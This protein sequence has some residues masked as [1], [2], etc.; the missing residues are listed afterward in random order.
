MLWVCL[1]SALHEYWPTSASVIVF[2]VNL[3]C[4]QYANRINFLTCISLVT[5]RSY[6]HQGELLPARLLSFSP[7]HDRYCVISVFLMGRFI[8]DITPTDK[9]LSNLRIKSY[10]LNEIDITCKHYITLSLFYHLLLYMSVQ[11]VGALLSQLPV[12]KVTS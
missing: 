8:T 4:S 6:I 1:L 2:L 11:W 9:F 10:F 5:K 12:K 7:G 3:T